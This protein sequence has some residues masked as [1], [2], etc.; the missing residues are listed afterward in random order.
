MWWT[1]FEIKVMIFVKPS[2]WHFGKLNCVNSIPLTH[3]CY[4]LDIVN[5]QNTWGWMIWYIQSIRHPSFV[6]YGLKYPQTVTFGNR[7]R[8]IIGFAMWLIK[9]MTTL[10]FPLSHHQNFQERRHNCDHQG[11]N[12][13][14]AICLQSQYHGIE[15]NVS[16]AIG[17]TIPQFYH[18]YGWE[19]DHRFFMG[20][21]WR[22]FTN[23]TSFLHFFMAIS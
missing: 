9:M 12:G 1:Y 10:F 8:F 2:I 14:R 17:F 21:L 18:F 7:L 13:V 20:G 23:I 3:F 6:G 11:C 19:S 4:H 15:N 22:C 5:Q 16:K